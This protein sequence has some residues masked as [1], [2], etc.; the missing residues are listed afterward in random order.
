MNFCIRILTAGMLLAAWFAPLAAAEPAAYYVA[1]DGNDAWSGRLPAPRANKSDGPFATL[2]RAKEAVRQLMTREP[3]RAQAVVVQVR[4]GTYF[5]DKALTFAPDDSGCREAPI[6]CGAF[7][8]EEPILSGGVLLTGWQETAPGPS[9][10]PTAAATGC[11][12]GRTI[13]SSPAPA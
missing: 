10:R 8:G 7:G 13:G 11:A 2:G 12:R 1:A 4:G 3:N 5:L 9:C 6:V